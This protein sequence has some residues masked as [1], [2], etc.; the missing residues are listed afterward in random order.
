[1][2]SR[3]ATKSGKLKG[4]SRKGGSK[5]GKGKK[6]GSAKRSNLS[7]LT[8]TGPV[9]IDILSQ[10][11]MENAYFICHNAVDCLEKRGFSW[12]AGGG[13]KGG[14]KGKKGKRKKK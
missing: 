2:P 4:Q 12:P 1:M 7:P 6:G 5:K 10:A 13:K 11:A 14:K 9:E 8:N 3:K